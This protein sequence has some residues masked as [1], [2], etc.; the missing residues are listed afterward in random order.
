MASQ[1]ATVVIAARCSDPVVD[2]VVVDDTV[3]SNRLVETGPVPHRRGT[4][5]RT[6]ELTDV[7]QQPDP[8]AVR[9]SASTRDIPQ[10]T[11][12]RLAGYLRVLGTLVEEGVQIVSSEGL[13][14]AAGVGSAKL[15]KDLSFLGP[16]G[17]RGVG[18]DV[19]RLS[20]RIEEVLGLDRGHRVI[21]I[22]VGNLGRA[23]VGYPGFARR[24]FA[25]VGLFDDD[26]AVSG[27]ALD[28]L[29]VRDVVTLTVACAELA[30]TIAVLA[31]PD[32]A[33]QQV[34][35]RLVAAGLRC[36]L[37]FSGVALDAPAHVEI[38][39]VDLAVELQLLSFFEMRRAEI[40]T[41][42]VVREESVVR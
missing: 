1:A 5:V 14:G 37:S 8:R 28:G 36:I 7:T 20:A 24:G 19:S 10:A 17:V 15:R 22:G 3:S 41:G 38:R 23:L 9:V 39:R 35:D 25:I 33:A 6:R 4:D 32:D 40:E 30:P 29:V 16:N 12:A 27:T 13:A 21:L 42:S 31:V 26:P 34:C 2:D 18:Y 11:V